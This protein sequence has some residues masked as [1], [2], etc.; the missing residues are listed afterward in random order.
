MKRSAERILTTHT[1][2]IARPDDLI[3]IMREKENGRPYDPQAFAERV[4]AAVAECVARQTEI[5]L[6]V[7]ND[8][9]QGKSGFTSYQSERLDGFEFEPMSGGPAG[10][11]WREVAEFP[12]YYERYLQNNLFGAMLGPRTRA[13]CRGPVR[14][15]GQEAVQADIANLRA[16]LEGRRYEEAFLSAALPTALANQPNE[17]YSNR[18]DF[19]VALADAVH[20]EYQAIID[21]GFLIQLDDPQAAQLWGHASLEPGERAKR[22]DETVEMINYSLRGIPAEKIRYHTCYSI[23]MGPHIYD[24]HLRD[25]V[26]AMLAV[27]AQ[28]ISFE[29]MNLRHLHDYH[30][31]EDIQLPEGK[32]VIPG[33]SSNGANWVEHPELIAELTMRYA[34]LVGRENVMI[35]NDCGFASQAGAREI[36][37]KVAWAKFSSLVEGA[38]LA[39]ERLWKS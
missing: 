34:E 18:E 4:R 28:A 8:G 32:I 1:G 7:V 21:A 10:P 15:I 17:Y 2:S 23:N 26:G 14:F 11:A 6:D 20:E 12:E 31:F 25:F 38:R 36:D 39:S 29:V 37:P 5:G 19:L 9:E 35:G 22:I 30:A 24:L 33:M 3:D 16:A 13:I 27:N